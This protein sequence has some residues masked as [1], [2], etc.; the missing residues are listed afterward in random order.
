MDQIQLLEQVYTQLAKNHGIGRSVYFTKKNQVVLCEK[1]FFAIEV[2]GPKVVV[3]CQ[4]P[5]F[6]WC[7]AKFLKGDGMDLVDGQGLYEIEEKMRTMGQHLAG[8]HLRFLYT[9]PCELIA[10]NGF[11]YKLYD[12]N[13]LEE[14]AAYKQFNNALNFSSDVLAVAAFY[15]GKIVAIAGADNYLER[16]LQIGVDTVPKFRHKGLGRYLVNVLSNEIVKIGYI[17]YYTT[18]SPNIASVNLAISAGFRPVWIE[19]FSEK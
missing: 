6:H 8:E 3:R 9:K 18:W 7:K 12:E 2:F 10:P 14:L 5:I 13:N 19:Y 17:P 11:I 1:D 15:D 16:M 4:E